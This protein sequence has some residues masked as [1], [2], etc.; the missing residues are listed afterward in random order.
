[1]R[2]RTAIPA[3]VVLS[4]VSAAQAELWVPSVFSDRMVLQQGQEVPVWGRA[5]PGE[6]VQVTLEG[7][8]GATARARTD[9][10]GRWMVRLPAMSASSTPRSL[11]VRTLPASRNLE[12]QELTIDDVLVGEV[13]VCSGQSN[14]QWTLDWCGQSDIDTSTADHDQLRMFTATRTSVPEPQE[15]VVGAWAI[16][17]RAAAPNLS[18][19]AYYFG[20]ELQRELDV[21]VGLI[22][23]S[24]GGSTAE[25]WTTRARLESME[26]TRPI[27]ERF[28]RMDAP[29]PDT[30]EFTSITHDDTAWRSVT[31]PSMFAQQGHDIDGTIWYRSH[32][33]LPRAWEGREL[34]VTLGQ[35]DDA[36]Q[37]WFNGFKIGENANW[38]VDR[39]YVIPADLVRPGPSLLTVRVTDYQGPGGFKG[40]VDRMR[41]GPVD[42][43]GDRR[44]LAGTWLMQ[45]SERPLV[46][47]MAMNHRPAHLYN[48][49]INPFVPYGIQGAIWYQGESNVDRADQYS[50]LFPAMIENWRAGW[51][52]GDFPFYFVQIAPYDYGRPLECA[53]LREAQA[54]ALRLPATGMAVTMDVGDPTD[55]HPVDKEP[56]GHRLALLAR[57]DVYG[58]DVVARSPVVRSSEVD[59]AAM[60]LRFKGECLPLETLDGSAP[61]HFE[62]AGDDR[63][64]HPATAVVDGDSIRLTS[65]SVPAPV[66][67]RYAWDDD[68]EPNLAGACGLPVGPFRTDRWP[69]VTSGRR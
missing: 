61:T 29:D 23:T 41:M 32:F 45:V 50:T 1:M 26:E 2:M 67:A 65:A 58:H 51:G 9:A 34:E 31:L 10:Q 54:A 35:I 16:C 27:L 68:A 43:P 42:A 66:A 59:G 69:G 37:V 28:D 62:L 13:W 57:A 64:Y 60:V 55:I 25:A 19:V 39:R 6:Q 52:E 38:E 30:A 20:R 33:D 7:V 12:R 3:C 8:D 49:M 48:G 11:V 14:M 46:R 56:V 18:A 36:D 22:H 47:P 15:D 24:W 40:P 4:I 17:D 5:L 63:I 21:P 53:E 44:M